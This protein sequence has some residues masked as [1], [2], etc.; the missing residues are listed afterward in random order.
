MDNF[1]PDHIQLKADIE[2]I[3]TDLKYIREKVCTHIHDGEKEG[4]FRDRLLLAEQAIDILKKSYWKTCIVAGVIGGL[5]GKLSPDIIN[6]FVKM[7]MA[8]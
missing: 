4:G 7:V 2:V 5:L 3:K 8:Q 1:C 6:F